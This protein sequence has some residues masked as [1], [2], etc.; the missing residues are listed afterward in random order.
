MFLRRIA[1]HLKAQNW[2]AVGI[3]LLIVIVGVWLGAEAANW[4]EARR[5]REGERAF[6]RELQADLSAD[7]AS[8]ERKI[9]Y[10]R[11][12]LAAAERADGFI[13]AGRPCAP[14]R[15]WAVLVDFFA[16]S[17]WQDVNA[18]R[19]VLESLQRSPYPYDRELERRLI[20]YYRTLQ[21][22]AQLNGL[23]DYRRVVRMRIPVR[24][25]RALWNC[26]TGGGD[27]QRVDL[28]C[29][30][31]GGTDA[32]FRAV[33]ERLRRDPEIA[34]QLTF[35]TSTQIL[36]IRDLDRRVRDGKALIAQVKAAA[37]G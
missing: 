12:V 36:A 14:G 26:N 20:E 30:P 9:V 10:H 3:D 1:A 23:S 17:Q 33:V 32:D 16:A 29:R 28:T 4:N 15:C 6:L 27:M 37:E 21:L 18:T 19:G 13:E 24:M 31:G 35:R 2:T 34:E 8:L 7:N 25:Q 22:T 5:V 11:Q